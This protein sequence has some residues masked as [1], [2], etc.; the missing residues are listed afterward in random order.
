MNA[1]LW[2]P[3]TIVQ[4]LVKVT[5]AHPLEHKLLIVPHATYGREL[6]ATLARW[7]GNWVG[8]EALTL[9]QMA[10]EL[11]LVPLSEAGL[12]PASEIELRV[13]LR[14]AVQSAAG[15]AESRFAHWAAQGGS[16]LSQSLFR[17]ISELRESQVRASDLLAR[18]G[19]ESLGA[20]LA[21]VLA[22]Y[23]RL[24]DTLR[25]ADP[26]GVFLAALGAFDNEAPYALPGQVF[27]VPELTA[28]GLARR[29]VERLLS[30]GA[31]VLATD[32]PR[33]RVPPASLAATAVSPA[34]QPASTG[35]SLLAWC[36]AL[37]LPVAGV[38]GD[39]HLSLDFFSA[40][41]PSDE[42]REVLR[43]TI[44]EGWHWHQ[45][46]IAAVD[47]ERYG[48]VLDAVAQ[49]LGLPV[50]M[51]HGI[52]LGR[53]RLGGLLERWF[54]WL[55]QE[56]PD[57]ILRE[58]LEADE[59][60]LPPGSPSG[61]WV[62]AELRKRKVGRGLDRY[63]STVQALR[64]SL[65]S[66]A[67]GGEERWG[68]VEGEEREVEVQA[69]LALAVVLEKL[70]AVLP[71]EAR[72]GRSGDEVSI[73]ELARATARWLELLRLDGP[74]EKR[75]LSRLKARLDQ[76]CF[77]AGRPLPFA[78]AVQEVR[79]A[80]SGM[81]Y[82]PTASSEKGSGLSTGG[83]L[84]F[85]GVE[86][87]GASGRPRVFVVGLDAHSVSNQESGDPFL[88]DKLRQ[89]LFGELALDQARRAETVF[90]RVAGLARL[91]G[92]VTLSYARRCP[93]D[94]RLSAPA[95]LLLQA[96]R[97]AKGDPKLGYA[98]LEEAL[99]PV[100]SPV[101]GPGAACLDERDL[102]LAAIGRGPVLL[103]ATPQIRE[104]F[105]GLARGL[106]A[107][108]ALE[109]AQLTFYHG[110]VPAAGSPAQHLLK[111]DRQVSA[112]ELERLA[113]C[114]LSW[115]YRYLLRL[116]QPEDVNFE[117]GAWL[118]PL[119]RGSLLHQV[120][121]EFGR[122]FRGREHLL[123]LQE[124]EDE[125]R[126]ILEDV[127]ERQR[128]ALPPPNELVWERE[129]AALERAALSFLHA[130]RRAAGLDDALRW[131]EVEVQ[132]GGDRPA[133]VRLPS[134]RVLALRGR[135]DRIDLLPDGRARIVDYKTGSPDRYWK[136][137]DSFHGGR[138]LQPVV[139]GAAVESALGYRVDSFEYL[140]FSPESETDSVVYR[141]QELEKGIE[142]LELIL[143]YGEGGAFVPSDDPNDCRLCDYR[144]ICRVREDEAG[145]PQSPRATWA[146]KKGRTLVQY[147]PLTT[148][149][150]RD[151]GRRG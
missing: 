144:L 151:E 103:N 88:G 108:Q 127:A 83:A 150:R 139:Y 13:L 120:F 99:V 132:F 78:R 138:R 109:E 19:T 53:T 18:A 98:E 33:G 6:L 71:Q 74:E 110:W 51:L 49:Q 40:A 68:E 31:Q 4:S 96:F 52:P 55:E 56:L 43:R 102:W 84:H 135:I 54:V 92:Q 5:E 39:A 63:R 90:A 29:L 12:R 77:L 87:A 64:Q 121:E 106:E 126:S 111:N 79:A 128:E 32:L 117:L 65:D 8:W 47:P 66:T 149:R 7:R 9:V 91:R 38:A 70:I 130:E 93:Q 107:L 45:V 27:F 147:L 134:G 21:S 146:K 123:E 105:P 11:A 25:L 143:S 16:S 86:Y 58:L 10:H 60:S 142:T 44:G 101:P 42:I 3:P 72:D 125:L 133:R 116:R 26:A 41:T 46:E 115:F 89:L 113:R 14:E 30:R 62:A 67:L 17:T 80:L 20:F 69:R 94:G 112:S 141:R 22:E 28:R 50:T 75:L 85:T 114:P 104:R 2:T 124:A 97:L 81:R 48:V 129:Y 137:R 35:D 1:T 73:A 82:W 148:I 36:T 37:D 95:P 15:G 140:F 119:T 24:L 100:A 59:L 23:E 136:D 57:R 122:R 118:D 34:N 61:T 131:Y 76:L 145:A